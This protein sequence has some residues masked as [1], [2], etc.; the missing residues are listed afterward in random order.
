MPNI[1]D[2]LGPSKYISYRDLERGRLYVGTIHSVVPE[3]AST[4]PG[5]LQNPGYQGPPS[6]GAKMDWIMWFVEWEKPF[7]LKPAKLITLAEILG[8]DVTEEWPGKRVLFFAGKTTIGTELK[9]SINLES[10]PMGPETKLYTLRGLVTESLPGVKPGPSLLDPAKHRINISS[11]SIE[12]FTQRLA[13]KHKRWDDFLGWMRNECPEGH[14]LIAGCA[15]TEITA[16]VGP[17]MTRYLEVLN[18]PAQLQPAPEDRDV[19]E[20]GYEP[21]QEEDIP[22]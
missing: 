18:K 20:E 6:R 2:M 3:Q 13:A 14:G 7:K 19:I 9:D 16:A 5:A 1:H 17:A 12:R 22:F 10:R 4:K 15:L 11:P 8:T 21:I